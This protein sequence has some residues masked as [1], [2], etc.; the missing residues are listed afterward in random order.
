MTQ[1]LNKLPGAIKK[2]LDNFSKRFR[3]PGQSL[4][5][6]VLASCRLASPALPSFAQIST[7]QKPSALAS[8]FICSEFSKCFTNHGSGYPVFRDKHRFEI[9]TTHLGLRDCNGF[10]FNF[11][12]EGSSDINVSPKFFE[13]D[14]CLD[15]LDSY[16]IE[17]GTKDPSSLFGD[18]VP[19]EFR[20]GNYYTH[21][22]FQTDNES[23]YL[24]RNLISYVNGVVNVQWTMAFF[25]KDDFE[26]LCHRLK[27]DFLKA[28]IMAMVCDTDPD[29]GSIEDAFDEVKS[30][31]V[32]Q[33][34][35]LKREVEAH[36]DDTAPLLSGRRLNRGV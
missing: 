33:P 16:H 5:D 11:R 4:S 15:V 20:E 6:A 7:F 17:P 28:Q 9:S 34:Q 26:I 22:L 18:E 31:P 24:Y 3:P 12:C 1:T 14:K 36:I 23:A 35:V 25:P 27:V 2:E 10:I 21:S 30:H 19:G 13:Y 29:I 32:F 8:G